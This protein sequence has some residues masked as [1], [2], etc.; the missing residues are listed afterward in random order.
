MKQNQVLRPNPSEHQAENN[1]WALS[2]PSI[3]H[4]A[5]WKKEK[6][7]NSQHLFI[8]M[9]LSQSLESFYSIT[10]ET[11]TRTSP[12]YLSLLCK[13]YSGGGFWKQV[14]HARQVPPHCILRPWFLRQDFDR[15]LRL[16][17]NSRSSCLSL[18]RAGIKVCTTMPGLGIL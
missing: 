10:G 6:D 13:T 17:L 16:A 2:F 11:V 5:S 15:Y 3:F 18:L 4:F 8:C 9:N 1:G 14:P 7:P 12:G